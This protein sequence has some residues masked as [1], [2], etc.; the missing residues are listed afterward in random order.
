[1]T[2]HPIDKADGR[3]DSW[4]HGTKLVWV[5]VPSVVCCHDRGGSYY[6][7]GCPPP[8]L[9]RHLCRG[10]LAWCW[11]VRRAGGGVG[12]AGLLHGY[13]GNERMDWSG[14]SLC[15]SSASS[16]HCGG[17]T[18]PIDWTL[19]ISP[20]SSLGK[21]SVPWTG[22]L[23]T[24][25]YWLEVG[26]F[27]SLYIWKGQVIFTSVVYTYLSNLHL[28]RPESLTFLSSFQISHFKLS[29][30]LSSCFVPMDPGPI[31]SPSLGIHI[32][33]WEI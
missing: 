18:G 20:Q 26:Y 4:Q 9:P 17:V 5:A 31:T 3:R 10:R 32:H 29:S 21:G 16:V 28:F 6:L 19:N 27:W 1:M 12:V 14:P 30:L 23:G 22:T 15:L 33:L 24:N 7:H 8:S 25:W 2:S 11:S 13:P